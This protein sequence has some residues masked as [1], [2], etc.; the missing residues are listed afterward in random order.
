MGHWIS[1]LEDFRTPPS[2]CLSLC[3]WPPRGKPGFR[4]HTPLICCARLPQA[5]SRRASQPPTEV[6]ET[7]SQNS[8]AL[9]KSIISG[10]LSQRGETKTFT[11]LQFPK[12]VCSFLSDPSVESHQ[13]IKGTQC[14]FLQFLAYLSSW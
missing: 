10:I 14:S 2:L 13:G 4:Y 12:D 7:V 11:N 8:F 1:V 6:S 5:L 3:F 9:H